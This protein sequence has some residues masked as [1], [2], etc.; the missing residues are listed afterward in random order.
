M[1]RKLV[2]GIFALVAVSAIALAFSSSFR[3]Q[4]RSLMV[5]H[6]TAIDAAPQNK[7]G[8]KEALQPGISLPTFNRSE[9]EPAAAAASEAASAAADAAATAAAA[10]DSSGRPE[11]IP[12]SAIPVGLP[13]IAYTYSYGFEVDPSDISKVQRSHADYC[14]KQGPRVCRILSL[15]QS[16]GQEDYAGATLEL[17]VASPRARSFGA[18]L[19][20]AVEAA[21]GSEV[22]TAITGEDLSKQ[23]VDTEARLRARTLLRDRLMEVLASR[24]GTVAE[25]VEAERGVAQVNEEIDEARSWLIEMQ[26]RVE[27]SRM[28]ISYQPSGASIAESQSGGFWAPIA[29]VLGS[30]G[31]I[32][33][34]IIAMLIAV[35]TTLLP[36]GL[37]GWGLVRLWRRY[38]PVAPSASE[39]EG[40]FAG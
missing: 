26:G 27:F 36:I 21:G 15:N 3:L 2:G 13:R 22:S 25:L 28:T 32:L 17:A 9:P 29:S 16:G 24:K 19:F 7:F 6:A 40:Q 34:T 1:K 5:R 20:K 30:V 10:A 39:P 18:E 35:L 33:G 31:S 38:R 8:M 11:G 4:Q 37:L 12:T 23:I 14:E